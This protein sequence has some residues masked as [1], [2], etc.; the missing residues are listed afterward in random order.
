[1]NIFEYMDKHNLI[2]MF[3]IIPIAAAIAV[4]ILIMIENLINNMIA[5]IK[6]INR[7]ITLR[8]IGWPIY[9]NMDGDGDIIETTEEEKGE[10]ESVDNHRQPNDLD[11]TRDHKRQSER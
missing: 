4:F 2:S 5:L 9:P 6:V 11:G 7:H 10:T 8:K 1:L 3:L